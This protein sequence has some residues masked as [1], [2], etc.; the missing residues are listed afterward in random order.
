MPYIQGE[1]KIHTKVSDVLSQN[2]QVILQVMR[3]NP[4]CVKNM[5][6]N[7][8]V[9]YAYINGTEASLGKISEEYYDLLQQQNVVDNW[10]ITGGYPMQLIEGEFT[11]ASY[12]LNVSINLCSNPK[13]KN[14]FDN[15][16]NTSNDNF[17]NIESTK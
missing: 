10:T 12:G 14:T 17:V 15:D 11:K 8:G 4:M 13:E 7:N 6:I 16:K 3:K 2:R 1:N 5:R 9:L